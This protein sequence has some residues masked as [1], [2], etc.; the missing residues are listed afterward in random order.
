MKV[1]VEGLKRT[2]WV[3]VDVGI[4]GVWLG[5]GDPWM[6]ESIQLL[7]KFGALK[8]AITVGPLLLALSHS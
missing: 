6:T 4:K 2:L 1:K 5:P 3:G 7:R 8:R